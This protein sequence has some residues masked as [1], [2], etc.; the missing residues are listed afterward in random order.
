MPELLKDLIVHG[1]KIFLIVNVA[2]M[3][4]AFMVWAERRV[5]ALMQHRLGP[6]RVG[7]L[8]L[9]QSFADLGKF[10]VKEDLTPK[11]VNGFF[12]SLAPILSMAP[13][14]I[15]VA[16]IPFSID[17]PWAPWG[18]TISGSIVNLDIG[19]LF[20]FAISSIG[21]YGIA[22]G[23]WASNSKYSLLGGVRA[24]AQM[25]S[26]EITLGLSVITL[27]LQAGTLNIEQLVLNQHEGLWY[28]LVHPLSFILFVVSMFAETNRHPFDMPEAES[29]L[30]SGY[31]TEYSSMKFAMFFLGEYAAM[32]VGS[33]LCVTLFLGGWSLPFGLDGLVG[34][35]PRNPTWLGWALSLGVFAAKTAF[36][37]FTFIWVR[38]TLPR[39][40]YDQ[41][42]R[43]GW[44]YMLP[45]ALLNILIY[46][47]YYTVI[48]PGATS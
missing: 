35:D 13:A 20:V 16:V 32:F 40:R 28:A 6:N 39:F 4:V 42:M 30:S 5:S 25:V 17:L 19:I 45:I 44:K 12:Y 2:Q 9:L 31:H 15:T 38:W 47:F 11:H 23:G 7:P 18:R 36:L 27:F 24:S 48:A 21:V 10:L 43:L 34:I 14:L 26:Y 8:G 33:A 1:A 46:A 22:I 37:V 29:E 3:L 41:L